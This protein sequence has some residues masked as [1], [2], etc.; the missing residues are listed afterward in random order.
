MSCGSELL[1][2][3]STL[4]LQR[5]NKIELVR[6]MEDSDGAQ[7]QLCKIGEFVHDYPASKLMWAP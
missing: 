6:L 1:F 2:A 7:A 5:D 4:K 3:V